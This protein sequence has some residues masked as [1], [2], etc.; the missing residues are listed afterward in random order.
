M[1]TELRKNLAYGAAAI[2]AFVVIPTVF[3]GI[4]LGIR[5][6]GTWFLLSLL[7]IPQPVMGWLYY[8]NFFYAWVV[9]AG[10]AGVTLLIR[11]RGNPADQLDGDDTPG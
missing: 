8:P 2:A 3:W 9:I 4:Y 5:T 1:V 7:V 6:S 10:C 11:P